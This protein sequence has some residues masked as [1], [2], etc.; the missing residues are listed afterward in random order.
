MGGSHPNVL[1]VYMSRMVLRSS[2]AIV[3]ASAFGEF[4]TMLSITTSPFLLTDVISA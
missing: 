1:S 2:Y 4:S 3:L